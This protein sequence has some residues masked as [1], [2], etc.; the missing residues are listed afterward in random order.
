[1]DPGKQH[2]IWCCKTENWNV[3]GCEL[4]TKGSIIYP[5]KDLPSSCSLPIGVDSIP[6][7]LTWMALGQNSLFPSLLLNIN[8]IQNPLKYNWLQHL[9]CYGAVISTAMFDF[10]AC[11]KMAP[12]ILLLR[13]W[14]CSVWPFVEEVCSLTS[15]QRNKIGR[16]YSFTT[17]KS[18]T[19]LTTSAIWGLQKE[20]KN[21]TI[22]SP[23]SSVKSCW[24]CQLSGKWWKLFTKSYVW[25][26]VQTR[27]TNI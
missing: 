11:Q 7:P 9:L 6:L 2:W 1:M 16:Y 24:V 4:S 10:E 17:Q 27:A 15:I 3:T 14:Q 23:S 25:S 26:E 13:P 20:R 21:V 22:L 5:E 12:C 18:I 8:E 19:T